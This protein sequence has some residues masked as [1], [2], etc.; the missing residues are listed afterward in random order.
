[1]IVIPLNI[2][3]DRK[4]ETITMRNWCEKNIG[5]EGPDTWF[6]FSPSY[7]GYAQDSKK[8]SKFLSSGMLFCFAVKNTEDAIAFKLVFGL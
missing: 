2:L 6:E 1:M 3:N 8:Y 5:A 7:N 4:L